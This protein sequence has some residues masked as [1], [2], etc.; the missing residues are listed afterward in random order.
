M[1]RASYLSGVQSNSEGLSL[2]AQSSWLTACF[3][4]DPKD[5]TAQDQILQLPGQSRRLQSH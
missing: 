4:G 5:Q 1:F 3:L 2:N